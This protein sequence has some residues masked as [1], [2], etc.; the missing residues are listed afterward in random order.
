R[1]IGRRYAR[2][3]RVPKT[4]TR[5]SRPRNVRAAMRSAPGTL[6]RVG[7]RPLVPQPTFSGTT[8]LDR[9]DRKRAPR[10]AGNSPPEMRARRRQT[11]ALIT[12][13]ADERA[14][15]LGM[16]RR[17]FMS[18]AAGTATALMALNVVGGCGGGGDSSSGGFAVSKCETRDPQ[19]ARER[20]RA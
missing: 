9:R 4:V 10:G 16:S 18:T 11:E 1:G 12:V 20:F 3:R 5:P 13:M 17:Q 7:I 8:M 14:G 19:A 15:A 2:S 6:V